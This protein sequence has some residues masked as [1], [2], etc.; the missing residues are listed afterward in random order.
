MS[1]WYRPKLEAIEK[2]TCKEDDSYLIKCRIILVNTSWLQLHYTS[3]PHLFWKYIAE[4][5]IINFQHI[6]PLVTLVFPVFVSSQK[7]NLRTHG[8]NPGLPTAH[9]ICQK[10]TLPCAGTQ[11]HKRINMGTFWKIYKIKQNIFQ[12]DIYFGKKKSHFSPR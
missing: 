6:P 7:F 1:S 3:S 2:E 5:Q 8:L 12:L 4:S 9:I 11:R 10:D